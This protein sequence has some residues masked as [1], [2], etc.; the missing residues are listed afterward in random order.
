MVSFICSVCNAT[1]KKPKVKN[2]RC[3]NCTFCCLDCQQEFNHNSVHSHNSC[4]SEAEKYQ[5]ALYKD[6][7]K[8]KAVQSDQPVVKAPR[9][10]SSS[11]SSSKTNTHYPQQ[12]HHSCSLL[13]DRIVE[14]IRSNSDSTL[15]IKKISKM[16]RP[17]IKECVTHSKTLSL[18]DETVS[19]SDKSC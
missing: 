15:T 10:C 17:L 18:T 4:I 11:A 1:V 16:L 6:K 9:S 12:C 7:K 19:L 8:R 5:G 2:H 13:E 3:H 14:L